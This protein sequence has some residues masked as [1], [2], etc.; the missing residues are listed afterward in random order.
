MAAIRWT[1]A[2]AAV[3]V[4]SCLTRSSS[5]GESGES[6][7]SV[8]PGMMVGLISSLELHE[9]RYYLNHEQSPR[10]VY[11]LVFC[12]NVSRKDIPMGSL[13]TVSYD[14]ILDGV[15]YSCTVPSEPMA[16][17][18]QSSSRGRLLLLGE[19]ITTP[20]APRILVYTA[21]FC[22][23]DKQASITQELAWCVA[24]GVSCRSG[25]WPRS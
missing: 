13:V 2:V 7:E 16:A 8:E 18:L 12:A 19:A 21:S 15:M 11:R 17:G 20:T 14:K 5:S 23:H 4:M 6:V 3:L 1:A 10:A 9:T 22:G 24:C 25:H